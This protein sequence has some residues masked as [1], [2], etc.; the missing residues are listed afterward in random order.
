M[1]HYTST[2]EDG[3]GNGLGVKNSSK[4]EQKID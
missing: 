3:D 1:Y 2:C 4:E